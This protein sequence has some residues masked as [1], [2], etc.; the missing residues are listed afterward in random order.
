MVNGIL[1]RVMSLL[2]AVGLALAGSAQ[3][4]SVES[5]GSA[6]P[7]QK[8]TSIQQERPGLLLIAHGAPWAKWNKPL[9][10]LEKRVISELGDKSP[11]HKVKMVFMEFTAPSVADGIEAMEAAGCDRIVA[12]PLLIAPSSHSHWDVPALLGLYA[13]PQLRK[14]LKAEGAR[15]VRSKLPITLTPTL[16]HGELLE[17]VML[18]RVRKLS[19]DPKNEAVIVLAH[20]DA[21][22]Q[23]ICDRRLRQ[24]VT[25]ICG[26]TGITCGDSAFVHVGQTYATDGV[27][28]IAA[29]AG[30]RKRVLVVGCYV[31]MGTTGMHQ[32]YMRTAGKGPI[33]MPNPLK[34]KQ[35]VTAARGLLPDPAVATWIARIARQAIR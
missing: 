13:D 15:L 14:E 4:P 24:V 35:I 30:K 19:S 2:V 31:S 18:R 23:P 17:A 9:L 29:A 33:P 7:A 20:G 1:V 16:D 27:S 10:D 21:D 22:L 6:A 25:H 28:A 34:G 26:K 5:P 8:E 32:R 3:P 12:V 11:F